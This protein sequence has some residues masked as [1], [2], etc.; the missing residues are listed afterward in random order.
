MGTT[1]RELDLVFRAHGCRLELVADFSG[2]APTLAGWFR[3]PR[4]PLDALVVEVTGHWVAVRGD[5]FCDTMTEGRP[6][7]LRHAPRKRMRVRR[8]YRVSML[9]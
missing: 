9:Q 2:D 5:W 3:L 7:R 1:A 4:D 6:V 8:V